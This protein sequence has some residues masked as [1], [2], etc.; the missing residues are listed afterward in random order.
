MEDC[1]LKD[2]NSL[3]T[4]VNLSIFQSFNPMARAELAADGAAGELRGVELDVVLPRLARDERDHAGRDVRGGP[5]DRVSLV[6][7]VDLPEHR[8][9]GAGGAVVDVRRGDGPEARRGDGEADGRL[10]QTQHRVALVD[11][12]ERV[13][14]GIARAFQ[15]RAEGRGAG[16][17]AAGRGEQ[18]G[19]EK[20]V[21]PFQTVLLAGR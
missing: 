21:P 20:R 13:R 14:R 18:G 15:V 10:F 4:F 1:R 12:V 5:A 7:A 19:E 2:W 8:A 16:G 3:P 17:D 9:V 6:A 11:G